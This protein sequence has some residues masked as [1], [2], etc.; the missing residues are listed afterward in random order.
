MR[1]YKQDWFT[2]PRWKTRNKKYAEKSIFM[3]AK[4]GNYYTLSIL[5]IISGICWEIKA[6]PYVPAAIID[7]DMKILRY[8]FIHK[9]KFGKNNVI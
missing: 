3:F 1:K 2:K 4:S 6:F 5:G 9:S 7:D 8:K